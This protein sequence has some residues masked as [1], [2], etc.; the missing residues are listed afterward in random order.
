MTTD[1]CPGA[2]KL[3]FVCWPTKDGLVPVDRT[4]STHKKDA[5]ETYI[6]RRRKMERNYPDPYDKADFDR[7]GYVVKRLTLSLRADQKRGQASL[8]GDRP[9]GE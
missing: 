1:L 7:E 8:F 6:R 2:S 3:W 5:V 9:A 4:G